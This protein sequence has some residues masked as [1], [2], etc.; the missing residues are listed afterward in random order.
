MATRIQDEAILNEHM[1]QLKRMRSGYKS[2]L[3]KTRNEL[4]E[5]METKENSELVKE[6][7]N[8][9]EK[10]SNMFVI[11]NVHSQL[12]EPGEIEQSVSYYKEQYDQAQLL[13]Q[14]IKQWIKDIELK[15]RTNPSLD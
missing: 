11:V 1:V 15:V 8:D 14:S 2:Q 5:L 9:V 4:L 12:V 13:S 10:I 3:T 6:R 7:Q